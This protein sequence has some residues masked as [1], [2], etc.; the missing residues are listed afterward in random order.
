MGLYQVDQQCLGLKLVFTS[1]IAACRGHWQHALQLLADMQDAD[2]LSLLPSRSRCETPI[3]L[4]LDLLRLSFQISV[5]Q[6]NAPVQQS[7]SII[8]RTQWFE[9]RSHC[10]PICSHTMQCWVPV[11]KLGNG[12]RRCFCSRTAHKA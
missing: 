2:S 10:Q 7:S 9:R 6:W 3:C 1:G 11:T 4:S 5:L 12:C 8:N